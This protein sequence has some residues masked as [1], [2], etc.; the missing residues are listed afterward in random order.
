MDLLIHKPSLFIPEA[1]H[2]VLLMD[3]VRNAFQKPFE[4]EKN[5]PNKIHNAFENRYF[6]IRE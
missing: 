2:T 3:R 5:V 6:I 1:E 4:A